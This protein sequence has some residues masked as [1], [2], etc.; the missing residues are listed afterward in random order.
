ML[1]KKQKKSLKK[2]FRNP[3]QYI[4]QTKNP[5][6]KTEFDELPRIKNHQLDQV[7]GDENPVKRKKERKWDKIKK[8]Y[9]WTKDQ[10]DKV[11]KDAQGKK[12]Y[13]KWKKKNKLSLPKLGQV[14]DG[15]STKMVKQKWLKTRKFRHGWKETKEKGKSLKN[16]KTKAIEKKYK[17]K[18]ISKSMKGKGKKGK[19]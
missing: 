4:S 13:A 5:N 16:N 18:L 2:D 19:K 10:E 14:E 6:V 17:K 9:I 15:E 11:S 1:N 8:N 12:A 3:Q 7:F